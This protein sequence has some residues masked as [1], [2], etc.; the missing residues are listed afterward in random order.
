MSTILMGACWPLQGM[1][2]AQ[3]AVLVSLADQANDD[4]VCW[5]GITTIAKRTCLSE[6]AVQDALAWLQAVGLVFREYRLNTST[7]YTITPDGYKPENAPSKR[8]RLT[9]ADGAP[10]ANG[11][12]PAN[13][14]PGGADG[15][16][17]PRKSRTPG[18]QMAHPG[19]ADGAPKSTLNRKKNRKGTTNEGSDGADA[20]AVPMVIVAPGGAIHTIP[21]EL[22]Y[23]GEKTQSHKTWI[24]YAIA[25]HG[26]YN[27]WPIWNATV[28]GQITNLIKRIGAELAPRV[29]VH[30]VRRVNEE[31]VVKQ[32]HPVK[33][34]LAD[35]EKWATQFKTNATI[36]SARAKQIDQSQSNFDAAD[37]AMAIIRANR[38]NQGARA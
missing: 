25:Y 33:L 19:G 36:T 28:G 20:P 6:R 11:A 24:A 10:G 3:K 21:G 31:F 13:G 14:A 1:S 2:P 5:P 35:A 12:P 22:R 34:L 15:A 37:E 16:P 8:A 4:G 29:A 27:T 26:R 30:F 38:E 7:S 9:G 32:M 18:V 23:P 17:P